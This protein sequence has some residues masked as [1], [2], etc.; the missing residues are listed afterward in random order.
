MDH[1]LACLEIEDDE[2]EEV[3][4]TIRSADEVPGRIITE[5]H[6]GNGMH[7]RVDD[8]VVRNLVTPGRRVDVH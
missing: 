3:A 5:A 1:E 6:P 7:Q 8:V 4:G 2:L